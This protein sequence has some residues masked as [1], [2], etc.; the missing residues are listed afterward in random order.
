LELNEVAGE[1]EA[2]SYL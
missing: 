1:R 2:R